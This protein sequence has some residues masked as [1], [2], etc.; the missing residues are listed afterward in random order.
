M[1]ADIATLNDLIEVLNDGREFYVDAAARVVHADTRRLFERMA[2]TKAAIVEDMRARVAA[3]GERPADGGTMGGRLRQ[4]YAEVRAQLSRDSEAQYIAQLEEFE[5]RI[6]HSFQDVII[7]SDDPEVRGVALKYMPDV[8]RD[9][10][11]MRSLKHAVG[12]A[13]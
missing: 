10:A 5:D 1:S 12:S 13:R 9:H 3:S 8:A 11:D 7:D 4:V 2:R 6:V